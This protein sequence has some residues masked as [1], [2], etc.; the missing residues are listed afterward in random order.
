MTTKG[1]LHIGGT[2]SMVTN[3]AKS[4]KQS[5]FTIQMEDFDTPE[6]R[7][8]K[9]LMKNKHLVSLETDEII[10][11]DLGINQ[12]KKKEIVSYTANRDTLFI[13]VPERPKRPVDIQSNLTEEEKKKPIAD[14]GM[15][16]DEI[17]YENKVKPF[18]PQKIGKDV[19]VQIEDGDLFNFDKD[20]EPLLTV[21]CGKI[22]E[23]T[24]LELM[25]EA[26]MRN[27]YDTKAAFLRKFKAQKEE[28]KKLEEEEIKRKKEHDDIKKRRRLER[29][30][31]IDT[32]Q[33]LVSRMFSKA[34]LKNFKEYS[35][36]DL[37]LRGAFMNFTNVIIKDDM[38]QF[39]LTKAQAESE[40]NK[41]ISFTLISLMKDHEKNVTGQHNA[42]ILERRDMIQKKR[43][44]AERKRL[45]EEERKRK[46][47]EDRL[48]RR[49]IRKIKRIRE[50]IK[51]T[52]FETP[53][54]R[55]EFYLEDI[56]EID[57]FM[58]EGPYGKK[59]Y[60]KIISKFKILFFSIFS[61]SFW[62][63]YRSFHAYFLHIKKIILPSGTILHC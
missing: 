4:K 18:I 28:I 2:D 9:T 59:F 24:N 48:E 47:E 11:K 14:I 44:D 3:Y 16:C 25:E 50:S 22:L 21:L 46:E 20:V 19:G 40:Y 51:K 35:I 49:R 32:Q 42:K 30:S 33:K 36:K 39:N 56:A 63:T 45:E 23:Q 29:I 12:K 57:N 53:V 60:K 55:N 15:Q 27:L 13:P 6:I 37:S 52:V 34:F 10:K 43:D 8:K 61:R 17:E 62:R 38:N 5:H 7:L 31:R 54:L 26:E 41:L 58:N 1:G